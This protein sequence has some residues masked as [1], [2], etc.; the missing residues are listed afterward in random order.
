MQLIMKMTLSDLVDIHITQQYIQYLQDATLENGDLTPE[1]IELL[2]NPPHKSFE[3]DDE[4]DCDTLL[5]VQLFMSSNTVELYN[6]AKEAIQIAHPVNEILSYDQ[7]KRLIAG[8]TGVWPIT[9]HMCP[10]SCMAYTGPLVDRDTCLHYKAWK[11]LLYLFGLGPGLLYC[12]LPTD[13]WRSYSKLVSGV[14]IIYQKS[15]TQTQIQVA[16]LHL[17]Q[18]VAK[19]E[20]MYIQCHED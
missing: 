5:S 20:S 12:V 1:D 16:H 10:N 19:F 8:I 15:I 6:G 17:I 2:L 9:K 3:F 14:C 18:F 7:V 4:H 13:I 11:F